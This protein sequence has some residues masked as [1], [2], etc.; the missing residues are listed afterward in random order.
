MLCRGPGEGR[1]RTNANGIAII[2]KDVLHTQVLDDDVL[3]SL[4]QQTE[5]VEH[6]VGVLADDA[7]VAADVDLVGGLGDGAADDHDLGLIVGDGRGEGRV[8]GDGRGGS[9]VT[10]GGAAVQ[11][12]VAEGSLLSRLVC[13]YR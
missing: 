2:S 4:D 6:G 9:A 10:T 12:G 11:A 13:V 7:G 5:A 1:V 8:R 3:L